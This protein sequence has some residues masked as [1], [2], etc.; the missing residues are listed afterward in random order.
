MVSGEWEDGG[1]RSGEQEFR[2]M[3]AE[4]SRYKTQDTDA[5]LDAKDTDAYFARGYAY[6]CTVL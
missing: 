4:D 5:R 6:N 2:R 1:R 3:E